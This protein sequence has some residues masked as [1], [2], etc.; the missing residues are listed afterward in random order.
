MEEQSKHTLRLLNLSAILH[1]E[2]LLDDL[3]RALYKREK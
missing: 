1:K 2:T 3:D